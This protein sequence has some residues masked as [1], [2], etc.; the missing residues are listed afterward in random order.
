MVRVHADEDVATGFSITVLDSCAIPVFML[1]DQQADPPVLV[2]Q[3]PHYTRRPV[4]AGIIDNQDLSF[5]PVLV[6]NSLDLFDQGSDVLPLV[7]RRDDHT[8]HYL[9]GTAA[10]TG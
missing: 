7:V 4:R 5:E 6:E 10:Y 9:T 8:Y 1:P 3:G 2:A